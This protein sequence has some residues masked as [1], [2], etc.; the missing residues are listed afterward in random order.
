MYV[1][2]KLLLR[3]KMYL[4]VEKECLTMKFALDTLKYYLLGNK[5]TLITDHAHLV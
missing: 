1:I 5:F 3:E 4:I 2:T